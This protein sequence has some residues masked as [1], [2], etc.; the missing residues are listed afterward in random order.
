MSHVNVWYAK[1]ILQL[2]VY[3]HNHKIARK[4]VTYQYFHT[5]RK[6]YLRKSCMPRNINHNSVLFLSLLNRLQKCLKS[7]KGMQVLILKSQ[8]Q[9]FSGVQHWGRNMNKKQ[10][11]SRKPIKKKKHQGR[12]KDITKFDDGRIENLVWIKKNCMSCTEP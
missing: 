4:N 9:R 6:G 2:I 7:A 8:I 11:K 1:M 10:M 12:K 5:L 3:C